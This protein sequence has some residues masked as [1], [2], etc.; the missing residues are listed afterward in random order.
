MLPAPE[1]RLLNFAAPA[2][3]PQIM[4]L[5]TQTSSA[6]V[7]SDAGSNVNSAVIV[8]PPCQAH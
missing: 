4:P 8:W 3:N 2:S 7:N 5:K 6:S 1:I